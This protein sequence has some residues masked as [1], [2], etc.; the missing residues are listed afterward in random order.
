MKK[1]L[2]WFWRS[3]A[4]APSYSYVSFP[5]A[6][7]TSGGTLLD[8]ATMGSSI[9][10][11]ELGTGIRKGLVKTIANGGYANTLRP[12][13]LAYS[14][15]DPGIFTSQDPTLYGYVDCTALA[16]GNCLGQTGATISDWIEF[17]KL[18]VVGN[19]GVGSMTGFKWTGKAGG[20]NALLEDVILA[21][22]QSPNLQFN[23][24][25]A[26]D[27][28]TYGNMRLRFVRAIGSNVANEAFYC[29]ETS[30]TGYGVINT[31]LIEH[32]F[33]YNKGWDGL[34]INSAQNVTVRN[35][36]IYDVGKSN[37]SGQKSLLQM[38]NIGDGALVENC[39]FWGAPRAFQIAAR[40]T[41]FRKCI[42]YSTE[43]GLYQDVETQAGY[44]SPLSSVG[45]TVTYDEC[46]FYS[47]TPRSNG[48]VF[49]E[50][51][52]NLIMT[53]CKKGSNVTSIVNDGRTDTITYSFSVT[54]TTTGT[55]VT[56]TFLSLD[57]ADFDTHGLVSDTYYRAN[58]IG[59]R[60]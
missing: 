7:G 22:M 28:G 20:S 16:S 18:Y 11:T 46:E 37:T 55:A 34:Q 1:H 57:K 6:P 52:A 31:L 41:T 24:V 36:T 3:R 42:F 49:N 54:G 13:Q 12:S 40:N 27:V 8:S 10:Q 15:G 43:E 9:T 23:G 2:D 14:S 60:N 30:T 35:V 33:G 53:N 29:G 47:S 21:D 5:S 56:P 32:C 17:H 58:N 59:Y 51:K 19:T 39:L 38:Q 25:A 45:G 44:T 48:F 50:N 4:V 26:G